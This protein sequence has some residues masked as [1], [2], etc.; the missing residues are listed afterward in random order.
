MEEKKKTWGSLTRRDFVKSVGGS[1]LIAGTALGGISIPTLAEGKT[2][3]LPKKWDLITDVLVIGSGFAGLAAAIEAKNAGV[4]TMLI[5]KMPTFG[6]NSIINGGDFSAAGTRMQKEAGIQD[7]PELMLKDMLK[8]GLY[9]NHVDKARIVAES[10]NEALEWCMNYLGANFA[11]L[12]YHGGH[13]VKRSHQTVNASGSE[14]VNK[15]LKKAKE[16]GVIMENRTKLVRLI[17]DKNGRIVGVEVKRDYRFPDET[18][19]KSAFIKARRAVVLAAGGFSRDVKLR[20]IHDPRLDDKF[21]S[22]NQPGATG[23]VLLAAGQ[24]GAMT[25]HLDWIQ[26]GPWTSPDEK[27][28]G[29]VPLF[30]ERLVGYGPMIN[31]KTGKRFFK[32]TGNRKERADAIILLGHPVIIMGDSYAVQKQVFP[33][34]L[35]KGLASGAIKKFDTLQ[36]M[37]KFYGIPEGPFLAEIERWNGFVEKKKDEDLGCMI[38]PEAKPTSTPPFYAA[39][40]WPKV[41]Y[42]MGG[43][44][45]D[46][47]A[48]VIGF[49]FKPIEGLYAAGEIV[50]AVHGAVRLGGVAMATCVVFGRIAGQNAAK[51]KTWG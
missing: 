31:P 47:E 14:V 46:T 36:E 11:R 44:Y 29:Y 12:T 35:E 41:H 34:A 25:V 17:A 27:G 39:R 7:S 22:T 23:E 37:A 48:R 49:D 26:L 6:G 43:L 28:F 20:L 24:A 2:G 32:E 50:G 1:A 4:K 10:S 33:Q 3:S 42:T 13:S 18:S 40:L 38:F 19:G 8:A 9:L 51:T 16:L 45:A 15:M 21:D 5:E 30:C